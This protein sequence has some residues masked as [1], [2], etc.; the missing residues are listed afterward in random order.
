[1]LSHGCGY[2]VCTLSLQHKSFLE[3]IESSIVSSKVQKCLDETWPIILQAV[4]L[5]AVPESSK[6]DE[7]SKYVTNGSA[8]EN[9]ISGYIMVHLELRDFDLLWVLAQLILF[10]TQ[11][12]LLDSK[13]SVPLARSD[14]L[15]EKI[16]EIAL[17][18][19]QFLS[20]DIFFNAD[21]FVGVDRLKELFQVNPT[22]CLNGF[23]S[24]SNQPV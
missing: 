13:E 19:L 9:S 2:N 16:S 22:T 4:A 8:N 5:D 24:L 11:Q 17:V 1:M 14:K 7:S 23:L 6:S 20:S 3:G 10:Q 18:T 12:T 15:R 21:E